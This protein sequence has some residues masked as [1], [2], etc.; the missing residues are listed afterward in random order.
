[1]KRKTCKPRIGEIIFV[2]RL[3]NDGTTT[4]HMFVYLGRDDS[5]QV[6]GAW[7]NYQPELFNIPQKFIYT[8]G[9]TFIGLSLF[10]DLLRKRHEC[11]E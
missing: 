10:L 1:M 8:R 5:R 11:H 7:D 9:Y 3:G 2:D 4:P 6:L